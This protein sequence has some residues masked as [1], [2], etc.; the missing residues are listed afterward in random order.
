MILSDL[1]EKKTLLDHL[2]ERIR[3]TQTQLE[4]AEQRNDS[5]AVRELFF[6]KFTYEDLRVRIIRGD[7]DH[8]QS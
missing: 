6:K 8:T 3:A 1:I 5:A 2:E 4:Q 7:F